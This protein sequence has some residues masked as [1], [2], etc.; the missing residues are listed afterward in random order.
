MLASEGCLGDAV[1]VLN[2]DRKI[3]IQVPLGR[4][5][6]GPMCLKGLK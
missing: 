4:G 3:T 6:E 2:A 1:G 5:E